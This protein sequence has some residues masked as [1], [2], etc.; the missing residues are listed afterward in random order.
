MVG[1]NSTYRIGAMFKAYDIYLDAYF[2]SLKLKIEKSQAYENMCRDASAFHIELSYHYPSYYFRH[3]SAFIAGY[4]KADIPS[5]SIDTFYSQRVFGG[6][7]TK[8][9]KYFHLTLGGQW[10]IP[11]ESVSPLA[12]LGLSF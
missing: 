2:N 3:P 12:M 8:C 11:Q 7:K 6:F 9:F 1:K 4:E 5:R 10:N